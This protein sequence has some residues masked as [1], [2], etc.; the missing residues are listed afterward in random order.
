MSRDQCAVPSTLAEAHEVLWRERPA[1]GADLREL[2]AFHRRSA[3]V[4]SQVA[5]IDLRHKYEAQQCAG[6]EIRKARGFEERLDPSL[7]EGDD[8]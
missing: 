2:V 1:R 3:E 7:V 6:L 4:Y 5:Q 8:W